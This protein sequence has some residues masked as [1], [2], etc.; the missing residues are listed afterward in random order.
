MGSRPE[1]AC[2]QC[3]FCPGPRSSRCSIRR[4]SWR[5]WPR[6]S[7]RC[8]RVRWRRRRARRSPRDG[9]S[10]LTM[11]GRRAGVAG[12]REARRRLPG[13][14]RAG[15]RAAPRRDLPVRRDDGPL[16]GADGRRGDHGA[17]HGGRV[18]A[19]GARPGPRGRARARGRRLGRP[20]ARAPADAAARARR[21]PTCGWSRAI[22]PPLRGSASPRARSRAPTSSA[23]AR[24][25]RRPCCRRWR[26]A[27]TSPRSASRRRAASSIP[28]WPRRRGCSWRRC[29]RSRRRR[30]A[31]PSSRAL[32]PSAGTE[33]GEVLLG[34]APGR[35][36]RRRGH[37]LQGDGAHR[38]GRRGRRAR[39]PRGAQRRRGPSTSTC[40]ERSIEGGEVCLAAARGL[41]SVHLFPLTSS[42]CTLGARGRLVTS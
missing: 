22:P 9:G 15:A 36:V 29:R 37:G 7:W 5:R 34:R 25:P 40:D 11:A 23:C 10:V 32:D 19:V 3:S 4:R 42:N 39:V 18:R 35:V 14:R 21:S 12:G 8:R 2:V 17:A 13:Q 31:V 24:R 30:R 33:L 38:R 41:A 20:G 26:Q 16:P 6:A 28:R 27:S 1:V